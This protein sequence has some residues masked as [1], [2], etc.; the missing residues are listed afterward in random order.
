M[1]ESRADTVEMLRRSRP[2]S[3]FLRLSFSGFFLLLALSWPLGGF[4]FSELLKEN[5]IENVRRFFREVVP[6]PIQQNGFHAA[7]LS[8][9]AGKL[10]H[11]KGQHALLTTL[12]I[13]VVAIIIA[14]LVGGFL[15]PFGARTLMSSQ[16]F[17]VGRSVNGSS[18]LFFRTIAIFLRS[19]FIALRSIPEYI[20]AFIFLTLLGPGSWAAVLALG[21]HNSGVLGKLDADVI[22]NLQPH[23]LRA[24]WNI[25]GTRTQLA[26]LAVFPMVFPRFLLFFFYRWETCVRESTVLGLLGVVSLGYWIQDSRART[27]YDEMLYFVLLGALLVLIGDLISL[28][29]RT[30]ARRA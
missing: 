8:E 14:G 12:A 19:V 20:W 3:L 6:Y 24:L 10:W 11:E 1:S 21:V 2:T 26:A 27:Y 13:S 16:P 28:A 22:E 23:P 9:W 29:A 5:R 30:V 7:L 18:N 4:S 17:L 15:S 25:G